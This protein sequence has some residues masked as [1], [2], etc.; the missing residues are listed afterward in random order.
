MGWLDD[1]LTD[2]GA[3]PVPRTPAPLAKP[4][5]PRQPEIKH[6]WFQTRRPVNAADLGE[7]DVGFYSVADGV[8]TMHDADGKP[9]GKEQRLG[10]GDDAKMIACRLAKEAWFKGRGDG[11]FNRPL[12]YH[13]MGYV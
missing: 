6:V 8:L 4:T 5:T 9:T 11:G 12:G 1:W 2:L 7:I 3:A 10:E 13:N